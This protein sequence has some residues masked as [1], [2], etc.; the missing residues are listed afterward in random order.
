MTSLEYSDLNGT[1]LYPLYSFTIDIVASLLP[2]SCTIYSLTYMVMHRRNMMELALDS[3]ISKSESEVSSTGTIIPIRY[4][5]WD[6]FPAMLE[7]EDSLKELVGSVVHAQMLSGNQ[8]LLID[9]AGS[10]R[11]GA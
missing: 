4:E 9:E 10:G 1:W 3:S 7:F 2:I 5:S 8:P 6:S 11:D